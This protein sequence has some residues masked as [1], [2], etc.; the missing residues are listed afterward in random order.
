MTGYRLVSEPRADL[1]IEAAF[2]WYENEQPGLGPEFLDELRA[3]YDRIVD[4]PLRYQELRS[5]IRRA[6]VKRFPY[7]VYFVVEVDVIVVLAVLHA[8]RDPAEWQRRRS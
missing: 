1:D 4:G 5:G 6:L 2:Q 3:T 8:S 7:A